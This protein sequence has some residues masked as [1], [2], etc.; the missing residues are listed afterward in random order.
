MKEIEIGKIVSQKIFPVPVEWI[1]NSDVCLVL[2]A[3]K[4]STAAA[5][6]TTIPATTKEILG[7]KKYHRN[8][9]STHPH[10]LIV[11]PGLFFSLQILFL[12]MMCTLLLTVN[13]CRYVIK[14]ISRWQHSTWARSWSPRTWGAPESS[15][16]S[17]RAP[18]WWRVA[19]PRTRSSCPRGRAAGTRPATQGPVTN[20]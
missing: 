2:S 15:L 18:V 5:T 17:R 7:E 8:R 1:V 12:K 11:V 19:E 9:I 16:R 4:L 3:P 6:T 14:K 20:P 13:L 10:T